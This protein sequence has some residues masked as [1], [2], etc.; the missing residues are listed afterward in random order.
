[1]NPGL[2]VEQIERNLV[3]LGYGSKQSLGVDRV[4]DSNTAKAIKSMQS[5]LGLKK[6]GHIRFGDAI[7]LPGKAVVEYSASFPDVGTTITAGTVITSLIPTEN[8][9]TRID[10]DGKISSKTESLQMVET[11]ITVSN[12]ELV[13]I[14][15][16]VKIEL[17]DESK[18]QGTVKTIGTTAVIPTGNQAN[19]PYLEVSV[20]IDGGVSLPQWTGA[21]VAVGVTKQFAKNVLAVPVMSLVALLEGGYA[22]EVID[23][24]TT[25]LVPVEIGI[26]SD[27][28]AELKSSVLKPGFEI[29]VPQ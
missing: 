26:Y 7:F 5:D 3:V 2:D 1:M 8:T 9:Q 22:V 15:T 6:T 12:Q 27:G 21:P 4:F 11:S 17:P 28:W 24:G 18:V 29:V 10:K 16:K 13:T 19:D 25:K 14:G 20:A 23:G